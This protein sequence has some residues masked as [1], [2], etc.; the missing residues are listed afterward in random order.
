M[1][2]QALRE[3][4]QAGLKIFSVTVLTMQQADLNLGGMRTKQAIDYYGSQAALARELGI[5]Q[6]SITDWGDIVPA[7]RQLQLEK[8]T[9]GKLKAS[10][11]VF[12]TPSKA[13]SGE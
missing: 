2:R 11:D 6:Q 3:C 1:I 12:E 4:Q 13:A 10:P 7:L 9:R 5:R 8:L